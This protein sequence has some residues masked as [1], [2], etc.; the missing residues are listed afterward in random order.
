M[1]L[2]QVRIVDLKRTEVDEEKSDRVHGKLVFKGRKTYISDSSYID[3]STRPEHKTKW[4]TK[5]L[6]E[7]RT[8]DR[9]LYREGWEFV[10]TNDDYYP[11][12]S[13]VDAEGHYIYMDTVLLKKPYVEYLR[14]MAKKKKREGNQREVDRKRLKAKLGES[15]IDDTMAQELLGSEIDLQ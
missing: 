8:L 6:A 3:G 14:D 1:T 4:V 13:R 12:G 10:T 11:E 7:G 5:V 2:N 15:A 9:F